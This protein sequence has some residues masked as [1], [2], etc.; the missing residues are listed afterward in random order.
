MSG[1][2][3]VIVPLAV[4][5]GLGVAGV[6]AAPTRVPSADSGGSATSENKDDTRFLGSYIATGHAP[7]SPVGPRTFKALDTFT[8]G[9]G[10]VVTFF[11]PDGTQTNSH[12][13]WIKSGDR[14]LSLTHLAV[15]PDV[16]LPSGERVSFVSVKIREKYT[17]DESGNNFTGVWQAEFFDGSGN[18]ARTGSGTLEATRIVVDP[19]D[20]N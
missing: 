6:A 15:A 17:F 7:Q 16:I 12:G 8:P 10:I 9:G 2:L 18:I 14:E 19:L 3:I 1:R 11:T 13:T 5:L 20:G 4:M